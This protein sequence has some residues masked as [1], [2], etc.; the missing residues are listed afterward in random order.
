MHIVA[1]HGRQG[2]GGSGMRFFPS[3]LMKTFCLSS[4]VNGEY[5][6]TPNMSL[7]NVG[8]GDRTVYPNTPSIGKEREEKEH[9]VVQV[10]MHSSLHVLLQKQ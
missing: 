1:I 9:A 4:D 3:T 10:L 5:A 8:I 2:V 7:Y 6:T